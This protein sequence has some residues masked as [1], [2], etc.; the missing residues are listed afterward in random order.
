MRGD[1]RVAV[2][3]GY[4]DVRAMG[5]VVGASSCP[6]SG[7]VVSG[8]VR[9]CHDW[10]L[11]IGRGLSTAARRSLPRPPAA[12]DEPDGRDAPDGHVQPALCLKAAFHAV[13]H[14]HAIQM[15]IC[16]AYSGAAR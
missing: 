5:Q 11:R 3:V 4:G 13:G 7:N 16:K 6:P 14:E 9:W 12:H 8:V 10:A 2:W 15:A 1:V